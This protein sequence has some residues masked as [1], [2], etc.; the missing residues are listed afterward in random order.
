MKYRIAVVGTGYMAKKHCDMLQNL[1]NVIFDTIVS[2]KNSQN[3]SKEFK[4]KYGFLKNTINFDSILDD[5]KIDIVIICSPDSLHAIQTS[6]LLKAGKHVL[7]EKPLARTKK[8]F[9]MIKNELQKS[10]K[11]LQVGMNC[12]FREQ[13]SKPKKIINNG[14]LGELK[15]LN[16]D[17]MMNIVEPIKKHEKR[18]WLKYPKNIFP[19]LHGGGIHCID[20]MRWNGG[21]VKKIFAKSTSIK[22]KKEF[23]SDTILILF[24]FENGILGNCCISSS[25][26]RPNLF[27]MDYSL[28]DGSIIDNTKIFHVKNNQAV[29]RKEIEIHQV[30]IDLRLQFENMIQSIKNKTSPMNSFQEAY[31]NFKVISGIEDS[32]RKD[33]VININ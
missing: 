18:W 31:E 28:T 32:I 27:Q 17:Y 7:C 19:V 24:E 13:Y 10:K 3:I 30:K 29:F 9:I 1:N 8:D 22:L 33:K 2:T 5:K 20:L 12:R 23:K 11:T 25:L 26:F 21:K 16:A 6:K 15:F 14:K 4:S